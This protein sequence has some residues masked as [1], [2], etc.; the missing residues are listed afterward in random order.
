MTAPPKSPAVP[1]TSRREVMWGWLRRFGGPI[2]ALVLVGVALF[3]LHAE[4]SRERLHD[5]LAHATAASRASLGLALLLT[6]VSF[7]LLAGYDWLS[8]RYVRRRIPL[9][10]IALVSFLNYAFSQGLGFPILTG[11]SVRIRLYSQWGFSAVQITNIVAFAMVTFWVGVATMLGAV[12]TVA[13][14]AMLEPLPLPPWAAV[15]LGTLLLAMVA[16]YL[17]WTLRGGRLVRVREWAFRKPPFGLAVGQVVLT[18]L[19]WI[20]AALVL[21]VL[22]PSPLGLSF[23]AFVGVFLIAFVAGIVSTVPGGLG[24]FETIVILLLPDQVPQ[25]AVL[26]ALLVYRGVY[27]LLP[28]LVAALLFS[29]VE[30]A[31]RR[32]HLK[33]FAAAFGSAT[34]AVT[35]HVLAVTTF[36]GGMILLLSGATPSEAGRLGWMND[37]LPLPIIEASHTLASLAGVALLILA[38]GLQRRLDAAWLL[39]VLVLGAG[40]VFSLLKGFDYEEA[41]LLGVMLVALLPARHHFYRRTALLAEPF[42]PGWIVAVVLALVAS[43]YVGVFSYRNV[44]L[45]SDVW[46][47]FVASGGAPRFLRATVAASAFAI[48]YAMVRLLRPPAPVRVTPAADDLARAGEIARTSPSAL[49]QVVMLGDKSL[50]FSESGRGFLMYGVEG[51]SWVA[52]GDP[53][54]PAEDRR[55]LA[56][57]FRELADRH[58]G[59]TVFYL[60]HRNDLA[61]YVDLGLSLIKIGEEARVP[62]DTFSL[63]GGER[64][65]MRQAHRRMERDGLTFE[66]VAPEQVGA[67]L[68]ELEEI[69]TAWLAEKNVREK[70]FSLGRFEPAYISRFPVAI[71]RLEGRIIAFANIWYGAPGTELAVDLMRFRPNA[72]QGAMEYLLVELCLWGKQQ[73]FAWFSLGMA[74]LSGM[75]SHPLEPLWN[76]LG[77]LVFRLGEHFYNFQGLRRYKEKF[78]PVWEPRYVAS[79]GGIN[80]PRVIT[81]ITALVSG[82]IR[83]VVSK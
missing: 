62:L 32:E 71:A 77:G 38:A 5:V 64:R 60:V 57:R 50:L 56:W 68:P 59:W 79:P 31:A 6:A 19:D 24:V 35:P 11:V 47:R 39:T 52:L 51:R 81:N 14:A 36:V 30:L 2:V 33:R 83:G 1:D 34:R 46:W 16:A 18:S 22:L 66:V 45:G 53:T 73:S 10:R 48:I 3:V 49:A 15:P 55:E 17:L 76:R 7:A 67:L 25:S 21:Y 61:L 82:G 26:G 58:G 65:S 69:S 54:G 63:E 42:T 23:P 72:H 41:T 74:P 12:L 4:L 43:V 40:I 78:S 37:L 75:G 80:L 28:L 20:A 70:G 27:Y 13:P 44:D 9:R 8:V 29:A